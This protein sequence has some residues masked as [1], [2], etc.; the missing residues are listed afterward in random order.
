[1]LPCRAAVGHPQLPASDGPDD[2]QRFRTGGH[3]RGQQRIG[4]EV[5]EIFLT[6]KDAQKWS[7]LS[8][9][10]VA[11]GPAQHRVA[12]FERVEH[13]A[14]RD[15]FV[16]LQFDF[17]AELGEPAQM[18]WQYNTNHGSVCTSTESTDGKCSAM[19]CQLLPASAEAYT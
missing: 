4:R 10:V 19:A 5:R 7:P 13:S 11:D 6:G 12:R 15:R 1:M 17:W 14:Q 3:G 2:Q 9:D 18:V 16:A 8:G